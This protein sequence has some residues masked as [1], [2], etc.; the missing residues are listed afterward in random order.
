M[1]ERSSM[2]INR[3]YQTPMVI[4][5]VLTIDEGVEEP[6]HMRHVAVPILSTRKCLCT[7]PNEPTSVARLCD[8]TA[9]LQGTIATSHLDGFISLSRLAVSS[10]DVASHLYWNRYPQYPSPAKKI[11]E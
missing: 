5:R 11:I 3:L 6:V 10:V 8:R 9:V 4:A 1:S 7:P 2:F